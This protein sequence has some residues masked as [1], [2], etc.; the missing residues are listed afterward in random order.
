MLDNILKHPL[1]LLVLGAILTGLVLPSITRRWQNYQK[2]L[3]LK[4]ELVAEM[5]K[6]LMTVL[7]T[8]EFSILHSLDGTE[9]VNKH[10]TGRNEVLKE[11]K[12]WSCVIGSKLHAYFP[13]KDE[14]GDQ[15][16]IKWLLFS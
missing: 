12:I 10:S 8:F 9:S 4:T 5:S 3:D 6:S 15:L 7:E 1:F 2:E 11:W 14:S 16:H 13:N